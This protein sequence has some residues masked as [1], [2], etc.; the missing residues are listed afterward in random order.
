MQTK[1]KASSQRMEVPG[2]IS[3]KATLYKVRH[4]ERRRALSL[5]FQSRFVEPESK[6]LHGPKRALGHHHDWPFREEGGKSAWRNGALSA[7]RHLCKNGEV[8]R[9][10]EYFAFAPLRMTE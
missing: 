6:D 3:P 8:L 9:L 1:I 10:R 7:L 2:E 4:P 5:F